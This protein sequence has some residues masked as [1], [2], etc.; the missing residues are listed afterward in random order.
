MLGR[1]VVLSL[2]A[3]ALAACAPAPAAPAPVPAVAT[4]APSPTPRPPLPLDGDG[5]PQVLP[6]PPD[7]VDRRLPTVDELPPPADGTFTS[8][9]SPVPPDVLARSTWAPQCPVAATDLR[10]VTVAFH[11]FDGRPHTG[12]LLLNASVAEK[13]AGAFHSLWDAGFPIERMRI[14]SVAER[15]APATGD[16]NTTGAFVCRAARGLTRWSAHAYGLA[17]DVDPFQNPY[18]NGE[19]VLPELASAYLDRANVR[20]GMIRPGDAAVRAFARIGFTWGGTWRS[21]VDLQHFSA[22]GD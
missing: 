19:R 10:Y 3:A 2:T 12:E 18:R 15:D 13:V 9:V 8:T 5:T 20:P 17:V 21:P 14:T 22:T 7:L 6:T 11:G 16:G 1:G 4:A